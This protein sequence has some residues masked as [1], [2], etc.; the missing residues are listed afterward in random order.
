[1]ILNAVNNPTLP[2]GKVHF[3]T[4][5]WSILLTS[6]TGR[7]GHNVSNNCDDGRPVCSHISFPLTDEQRMKIKQSHTDLTD[8]K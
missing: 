2:F 1:M 7:E 6:Q 3:K 4:E 8:S 5:I